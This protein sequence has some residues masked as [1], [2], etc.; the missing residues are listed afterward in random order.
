MFDIKATFIFQIIYIKY[1]FVGDNRF[2][3]FG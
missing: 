3:K 2:Q 1:Y